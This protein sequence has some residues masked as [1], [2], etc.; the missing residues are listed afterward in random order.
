MSTHRRFWGLSLAA[1][2]AVAAALSILPGAAGSPAQARNGGPINCDSALYIMQRNPA[3]LY[4]IDRSNS[5]FDLTPIGGPSVQ[6]N[7]IGFNTV[8]NYIYGIDNGGPGN[9]TIYR[10]DSD[11]VPESVGI[12]TGFPAVK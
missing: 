3:Q 4:T 1:L 2:L 6:Y 5:P 9:G 8:D 12:P 10:I 11:G 7:A